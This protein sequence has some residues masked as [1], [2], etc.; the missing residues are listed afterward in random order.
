VG[1]SDA[2]GAGGSGGA[3]GVGST[4]GSDGADG[5][6]GGA[7]DAESVGIDEYTPQNRRSRNL[8]GKAVRAAM[9]VEDACAASAMVLAEQLLAR[10][11]RRL[12]HNKRWA[13]W[14]R[15]MRES[16][17][18]EMRDSLV[19]VADEEL[20]DEWEADD[21][22]WRD[23]TVAFEG[24][25]G[26]PLLLG[27]WSASEAPILR[28]SVFVEVC[29]R[30]PPTFLR[31]LLHLTSTDP[32][33]QLLSDALVAVCEGVR[34]TRT[35]LDPTV[36]T[37][38]ETLLAAG[39]DVNA[40]VGG[41]TPLHYIATTRLGRRWRFAWSPEDPRHD[42]SKFKLLFVI[43]LEYGAR[44]EVQSATLPRCS[45]CDSHTPPDVWGGR[46]ETSSE[47]RG[48]TGDVVGE[49]GRR[50]DCFACFNYFLST[51]TI[52]E[53][54]RERGWEKCLRVCVETSEA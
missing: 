31:S 46:G 32:S 5:G 40:V 17:K 30:S 22:A 45:P 27:P 15:A 3:A 24:C 7:F 1:D 9:G 6:A 16:P 26:D 43:F 54:L 49:A 2:D 23:R 35:L 28:R 33:P 12:P 52:P 19:V 38:I 29:L 47:L 21:D 34:S 51:A 18:M 4:D 41:W 8:V 37:K 48:R 36:V 13:H 20:P 25:V 50:L 53:V 11:L 44:L 10:D 14:C 42:D 39:A